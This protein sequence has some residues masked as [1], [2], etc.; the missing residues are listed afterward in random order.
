MLRSLS[1]FRTRARHALSPPRGSGIGRVAGL[2]CLVL[3]GGCAPAVFPASALRS[4]NRAVGAADLRR[5]PDAYLG[6]HVMVGGEVL[7]TRPAPGQTEVE[8]L[9]RRLRADDSP[10]RTDASDGRVLVRAAEFL[11]PA[12]YAAGRRVTVI[13]AVAGSEERKI[14]ELPY[15]YPVLRAE[16][17]QLWPRDP[18]RPPIYPV[19]PYPWGWPYYYPRYLGPWPGWPY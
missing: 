4:V 3:A 1:R 17:I 10:E 14:G 5:D 8:L 12:V 13:G 16:A 19:Y 9:C 11:D 18:P 6:Q 7:A 2:V 15:R